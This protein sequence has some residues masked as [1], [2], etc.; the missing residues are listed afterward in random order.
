MKDEGSIRI[1]IIISNDHAFLNFK[2]ENGE[3]KT[4]KTKIYISTLPK[5]H[6][7]IKQLILIKNIA[8]L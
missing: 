6:S 1:I 5:I 7:E 2:M 8:V 3:I 4:L